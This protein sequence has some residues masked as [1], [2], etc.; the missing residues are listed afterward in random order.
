MIVSIP[1]HELP[2]EVIEI[3]K[4]LRE[5][6]IWAHGHWIIYRQ[7]YN[8]SPERLDLLNESAATFFGR[9]QRILLN[10]TILAI[11]RLT[12]PATMGNQQNLS[13]EMLIQKLDATVNEVIVQQLRTDL[14]EIKG[15]CSPFRLLRNKEVAHSDFT[16]AMEASTD[17]FPG[18]SSEIVDEAVS[19]IGKFMNIFETRFCSGPTVYELF[20][21]QADGEALIWQLKRA[22]D[23]RD[24][25]KDGPISQERSLNMRFR[26]A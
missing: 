5:D 19:R 9:L 10:D 7:L 18:I 12:D 8:R 25:H 6:V 15:L 17:P 16:K 13:L 14:Q 23:W 2:E 4:N 21:M 26:G 20:T 1:P 11:G 24:G 3:Y 22:A